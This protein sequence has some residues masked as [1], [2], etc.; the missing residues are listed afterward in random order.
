MY[1]SSFL[2]FFL[3][4]FSFSQL[5]KE[6]HRHLEFPEEPVFNPYVNLS[7][8]IDKEFVQSKSEKFLEKADLSR[9]LL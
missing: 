8:V 3:P 7:L 1:I 2:P 5:L 4:F 6:A 9:F